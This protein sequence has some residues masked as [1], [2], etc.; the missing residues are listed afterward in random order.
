MAKEIVSIPT[1][2]WGSR[3]LCE[4]LYGSFPYCLSVSDPAMYA[5]IVI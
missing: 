3:A 4:V 1:Q 2:S 5:I